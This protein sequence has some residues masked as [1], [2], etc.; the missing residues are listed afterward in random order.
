MRQISL[1][2]SATVKRIALRIA[3]K[4]D[5]NFAMIHLRRGDSLNNQLNYLG[6]SARRVFSTTS[7]KH[8]TKVMASLNATHL[9]II[10]MTNEQSGR[11]LNAMNRLLP[12]VSWEWELPQVRRLREKHSD[13][14]EIF[15]MLRYLGYLA[16]IR[17]GT[18]KC[19]FYK[20]RCDSLLATD[21][22]ELS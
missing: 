9:P 1:Q 7:P 15:Q 20:G 6:A 21:G 19:Y 2:P 4:L 3:K 14:I 5:F 22:F 11:Y 8:V 12:T 10:I 17:V 18:S 13:N 16:K